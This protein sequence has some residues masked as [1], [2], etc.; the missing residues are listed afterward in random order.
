M[1]ENETNIINL[2][3]V[4]DAV[5][6][7]VVDAGEY[8]LQIATASVGVVGEGKKNAGKP[9]LKVLFEILNEPTAKMVGDVM[10]F[11]HAD[12]EP[13]ALNQAKLGLKKF[14][15][16]FGI[17]GGATSPDS[18]RGLEGWAFLGVQHDE[19]YGDKNTVKRYIAGR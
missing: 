6:P 18:M 12:M 8:K 7:M 9:Y 16:A 13:K 10:M 17:A 15:E 3:D 2:P 4:D 14:Y 11:P 19:Q 5:E 1:N